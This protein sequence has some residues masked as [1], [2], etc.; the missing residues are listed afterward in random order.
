MA[1][2]L[3]KKDAQRIAKQ[4]E[5]A[6]KKYGKANIDLF[7]SFTILEVYSA[8][9]FEISFVTLF[10]NGLFSILTCNFISF[11]L[12]YNSPFLN[13]FLYFLVNLLGMYFIE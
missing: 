8:A 7:I 3:N 13:V 12:I 10:S 1:W 11:L 6:N 4:I 9:I 2:A 5:E